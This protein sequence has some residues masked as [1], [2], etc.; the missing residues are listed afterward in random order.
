MIKY[1]MAFKHTVGTMASHSIAESGVTGNQ[2]QKL[3]RSVQVPSRDR[4]SKAYL[5]FFNN[6]GGLG[7]GG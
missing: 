4:G 6:D 1:I 2:S 5:D 3:R 7:G